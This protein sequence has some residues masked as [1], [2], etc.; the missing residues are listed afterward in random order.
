MLSREIEILNRAT[1]P[2]AVSRIHV[3]ELMGD[4]QLLIQRNPE[5]DVLQLVACNGQVSLSVHV[6]KE[7]SLLRLN[8]VGLT[9]ETTGALSINAER[10]AMHGRDGVIISSGADA[11]IKAAG[12]LTTHAQNQNISAE[13]G[14]INIRANDDVKL[15]GE[16]IRMNC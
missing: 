16:R 10:V 1:L 4:Q 9:I 12:E 8:G 3:L 11:E 6:T 7:G 5:S 15:D 14:N 13:L 2:I